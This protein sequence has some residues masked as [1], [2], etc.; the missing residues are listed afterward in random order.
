VRGTGVLL[1]MAS[2]WVGPAGAADF[3]ED[4]RALC[5][6]LAGS[7]MKAQLE[8]SQ[9]QPG[10]PYFCKYADQFSSS[11][12]VVRGGSAS[13]DLQTGEVS[14]SLVVQAWSLTRREA[15]DVFVPFVTEFYRAQGQEVPRPI[16]DLIGAG[17]GAE[18]RLGSYTATVTPPDLWENQRAL[19]LTF[20][21]RAT[22]AALS[23]VRRGPTAE[24]KGRTAAVKQ[25]LAERCLAAIADSGQPAQRAALREA[26]TQLSASR[27][28]FEYKDTAGGTFSCQVCDESDPKVNC[29]IMGATLSY[30][31]EGGAA[32][33]LPAELD[34]KCVFHLQDKL[35]PD[36][37][38]QFI[39]HSLVRR[40]RVSPA[41][42]ESRWVYRLD[43]DG[44]EFRCVIRKSDGSFRLEGR[45][46]GDWTPLAG[47]VVF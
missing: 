32:K 21:A 6:F 3:F 34:R 17:K 9:P 10:G 45:G 8:W 22:P 7:G 47:G 46:S 4:P 27:Y 14:L 33:T 36:D 2:L 25:K 41:H 44:R 23:E 43:L 1:Q 42:T 28:L 31:P 16:V 39:D 26:A 19:G 18:R 29:G 30:T 11:T 37:D 13:I 12:A 15:A 20:T 40:I 24:E 5:A 38:G 35:K